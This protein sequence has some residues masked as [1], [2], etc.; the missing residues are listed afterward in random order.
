[1]SPRFFIDAPIASTATTMPLPASVAHHATRVLRLSAG[2]SLVLFD[3]AGGEY[4]ATLVEV[5]RRGA[6]VRVDRFDPVERESPLEITLVQSML[7]TDAMDYAVR[8]AVELGAAAIQP[9]GAARSQLAHARKVAHWRGIAIAACEQCGRNRVPPVAVPIAFDA[10]LDAP[11][12]G[13]AVIA[14]PGASMSLSAFATRAVPATIVV[15]PEGGFTES[16]MA[17][18]LARG[19]EAVHLGPRVLRAETAGVA[20]LAMLAALVGDAR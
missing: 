19:V 12:S 2:D 18:A 5:D 9:I 1:M 4:R 6:S 13:P 8:K 16:E 3:G 10:W 7:A 15:G 11:R 20:A 14:G 17:R